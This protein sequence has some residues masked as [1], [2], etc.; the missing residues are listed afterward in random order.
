MNATTEGKLAHQLTMAGWLCVLLGSGLMIA[1]MFLFFLYVPLFMAAVVL[2]IVV[3]VR[4]R[5]ASGATLLAFAVLFPFLLG[6]VLLAR[7]ML[8]AASEVEQR[9][10]ARRS[11][12][13]EESKYATRYVR[14]IDVQ[15]RYGVDEHGA[16]VATVRFNLRNEGDRALNLVRTVVRFRDSAGA[17]IAEQ[18]HTPFIYT[19]ALQKHVTQPLAPRDTWEMPADAAMRGKAVPDTWQ[20]GSVDVTVVGAVYASALDQEAAEAGQGDDVE[21]GPVDGGVEAPEPAAAPPGGETDPG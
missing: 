19:F 15:S 14:P 20:E 2:A 21:T 1:S 4:K 6:G 7:G 3:M 18:K 9:S 8:R 16:R 11:P 10:A 13:S 5:V 17:V 12:D